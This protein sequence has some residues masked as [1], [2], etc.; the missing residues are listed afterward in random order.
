[1][2]YL[3]GRCLHLLRCI[4]PLKPNRNFTICNSNPPFLVLLTSPPCPQPSS[5]FLLIATLELFKASSYVTPP[6]GDLFS[7]LASPSPGITCLHNLHLADLCLYRLPAGSRSPWYSRG[8]CPCSYLVATAGFG[9]PEQISVLTAKG[10]LS[11]SSC[12]S[13]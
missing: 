11:V 9:V 5:P 10:C 2:G 4:P 3:H 8:S 1:M 6:C 13:I 7:R 12:Y